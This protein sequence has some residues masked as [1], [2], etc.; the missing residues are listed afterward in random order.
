MRPRLDVNFLLW[1][2]RHVMVGKLYK[3]G[4]HPGF[5]DLYLK[6]FYYD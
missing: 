2:Q 3:L 4:Y 1:M 6:C 5:V